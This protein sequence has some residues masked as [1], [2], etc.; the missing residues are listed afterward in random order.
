MPAEDRSRP[1]FSV[2]DVEEVVHV[3]TVPVVVSRSAAGPPLPE[4]LPP[5]AASQR[6]VLAL[7]G[8]VPCPAAVVTATVASV[9]DWPGLRVQPRWMLV[10]RLVLAGLVA[11]GLA[12]GV[13]TA[14]LKAGRGVTAGLVVAGL[15]AEPLGVFGVWGLSSNDRP[16]AVKVMS[17]GVRTMTGWTAPRT[18]SIRFPAE[19]MGADAALRSQGSARAWPFR[20]TSVRNCAV[21]TVDDFLLS[22]CRI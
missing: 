1:D 11:V 4:K 6:S 21:T 18:V 9:A 8:S 13:A 7:A 17:P 15:V 10:A 20:E 19:D 22:R 2:P 14:G 16:T 12:A 3:I 5:G